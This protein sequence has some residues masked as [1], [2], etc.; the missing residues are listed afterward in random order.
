MSRSP[1]NFSIHYIHGH[2]EGHKFVNSSALL[3]L[4]FLPHFIVWPLFHAPCHKA[5]LKVLAHLIVNCQLSKSG[6]LPPGAKIIYLAT[7]SGFF[8][9]IGILDG[10]LWLY[11][12]LSLSIS[13]T[14]GVFLVVGEGLFGM[15]SKMSARV[16]ELKIC[17]T[18]QLYL[19]PSLFREIRSGCITCA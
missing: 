8:F 19:S 11:I 14:P 6:I 13:N 2:V 3:V 12:L 7:R 4:V 9:T 18:R 15:L 16:G 10:L 17:P 5:T 1:V